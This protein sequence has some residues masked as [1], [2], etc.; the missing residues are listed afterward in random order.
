MDSRIVTRK[1]GAG[2]SKRPLGIH[3]PARGAGGGSE[4][5]EGQ[6]QTARVTRIIDP[7]EWLGY[8][9]RTSAE[10]GLTGTTKAPGTRTVQGDSEECHGSTLRARRRTPHL[11]RAIGP[12]RALLS[13]PGLGGS[14]VGNARRAHAR[15][16]WSSWCSPSDSDKCLG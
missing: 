11:R 9:T 4:L 1:P 12:G 6:S 2:T 15:L 13:P 3:G 16:Q 8:L 14:L 5:E 10:P 7:D